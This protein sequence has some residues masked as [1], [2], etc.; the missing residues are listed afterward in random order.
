MDAIAALRR[1]KNSQAHLQ[2]AL[3]GEEL[4][5]R[6]EP[7]PD[8]VSYNFRECHFRLSAVENFLHFRLSGLLG[9]ELGGVEGC[10]G[11]A[12]GPAVDGGNLNLQTF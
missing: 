5:G 10:L 4:R 11:Q 1:E 9:H 12:G 3:V 7:V 2:V 6:L 8:V